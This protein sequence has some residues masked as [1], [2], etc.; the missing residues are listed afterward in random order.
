MD[1]GNSPTAN[2]LVVST[3]E[4]EFAAYERMTP[5]VRKA[6]QD[7][8]GRYSALWLSQNYSTEAEMLDAILYG[9]AQYVSESPA[10]LAALGLS[11]LVA[12]HPPA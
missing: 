6:L 1:R 2:G 8:Y 11:H 4:A 10:T 12:D 3:W 5:R 7:A 9:D